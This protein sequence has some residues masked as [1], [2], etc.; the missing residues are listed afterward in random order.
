MSRVTDI[1]REVRVDGKSY[2]I[3]YKVVSERKPGLFGV[4]AKLVSTTKAYSP[5]HVIKGGIEIADP[6]GG[7]EVCYTGSS[8][9]FNGF[10]W[11]DNPELKNLIPDYR[12][13]F[14][15]ELRPDGV[16][17]KRRPGSYFDVHTGIGGY[18]I[19][20]PE[21]IRMYEQKVGVKLDFDPFKH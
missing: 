9:H 20:H 16:A 19:P 5:A 18:F 13:N 17:N 11:T 3:W 15:I 4:R 14:T 7:W 2:M 10:D 12:P 21:A 1:W 8:H 6:T